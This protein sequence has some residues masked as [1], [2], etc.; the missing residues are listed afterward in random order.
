MYTHA[1]LRYAEALWRHG[2]VDEFFRAL[3]LA[4]PIG[5]RAL[6]PSAK[7]RQANCYYTSSDA[8]FAD[9]YEAYD[10]YI[11]AMRGCVPTEGGWRI[12]SSGPGVAVHLILCCFLG[13]RQE[14]SALVLDPAIPPR[15]NG[16][17]V[18]VELFGFPFEVTIAS[19]ALVAVPSP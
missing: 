17:R 8:A 14:K 18:E 3:C 6:T 1:H 4:N 15:L 7:P 13:L 12:Y 10:H 19:S 9:R 16:L 5:I 2:S 11:G